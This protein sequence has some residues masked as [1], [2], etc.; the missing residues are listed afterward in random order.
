MAAKSTETSSSFRLFQRA[1]E[2]V[3]FGVFL[4]TVAGAAIASW[5]AVRDD[6]HHMNEAIERIQLVQKFQMQ[7]AR[8]HGK[9]LEHV[10]GKQEGSPPP[11]KPPELVAAELELMQ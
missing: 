8:H 10:A 1:R 3:V 9:V 2:I 7:N 11:S 5:I 6:L 4:A